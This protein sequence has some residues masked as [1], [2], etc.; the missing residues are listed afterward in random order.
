MLA[1]PEKSPPRVLAE[2]NTLE[3]LRLALRDRREALDI[4]C[5]LVDQVAGLTRGHTSKLLSPKPI[6][7]LGDTTL[8]LLLSTFGLRLVLLEDD[9]EAHARLRARLVPREYKV[10]V[11]AR[12]WGPKARGQVVSLRWLRK[13]SAAGG[14]A[15]AAKLTPEQRSKNARRAAKA[16]AR[17]LTAEQRSAAARR[18][19]VVKW[20]EIKRLVR[21][22]ALPSG[23]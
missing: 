8:P 22:A 11:R 4:S 15:T 3:G 13:I 10:P 12:P 6:K 20:S 14:H 18:A 17:K 2:I 19:A 21:A 16:R 9:T 23:L 5:D 1:P 7:R